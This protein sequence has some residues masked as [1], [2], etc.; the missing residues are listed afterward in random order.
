MFA[1]TGLPHHGSRVAGM[2]SKGKGESLPDEMSR[3]ET[4]FLEL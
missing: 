2:M 4:A 1:D 3:V